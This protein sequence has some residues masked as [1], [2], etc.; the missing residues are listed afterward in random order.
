[1]KSDIPLK[2]TDD[3]TIPGTSPVVIF[4]PNGAGKTRHAT[5]MAE[6]NNADMI[7]ALRNIALSPNLDMLSLGKAS[8]N[9][10]EHLNQ[11]RSQAWSQ[12]NEIN[13]LFSKLMAEDSTA[14]ILFRDAYIMNQPIKPENTKI[15][16]LSK[17]WARLF[18]GM[19]IDFSGYQ[20]KVRSDFSDSA[21]E[22]PAERMSDGERVALYLAGRVL[23]SESNIIIIDEPEVHFH[24]RLASR[25]WNELETLRP[26]CRF[27]YVTHDL[28]F[29][30]SRNNAQYV[31]IMPNI[32]PQLVSLDDGL[33]KDLANSLLA[34]A[35][36]SIY[37]KRIVFCEGIEGRSRDQAIYSAW[38]AGHETAVVPVETGDNAVQCARTYA[39]STLVAGVEAL[40]IIDRD[41]WPDEYLD[42]LPSY[43][44]ALS[45]HELENLLCL[46]DVFAAIATH[47]G[48]SDDE[49]NIL[50]QSFIDEAKSKFNGTLLHK[51]ISERY[52]RRC[53]KIFDSAMNALNVTN[54]LEAD[55]TNHVR[56]LDLSTR[57]TDPAILFD[58]EKKRL[59]EAL[60][61]D[62]DQFLR[63][64]PGKVFVKDA[65]RKLGLDLNTYIE[66]TCNGLTAE[67][68]NKLYQLGQQLE[69]CLSK[70]LPERHIRG[71]STDT[72]DQTTASNPVT[73]A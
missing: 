7:K 14:A 49:A 47:L 19:Q 51:Q 10:R 36:F 73:E 72:P 56:A 20:P 37:A 18:P 2:L 25:F 13:L 53:K 3:T 38:F 27:V 17:V 4:G 58:E 23:D 39:E 62:E 28:S 5:R 15:M 31:I 30:L 63:L 22:Y 24:S 42:S 8:T 64:Y 44:T 21:G 11:T 71:D 43:I 68:G 33:P 6:L 12:S 26:E 40:A 48:R 67:T 1:M 32:P 50:Y 65:A 69:R 9:L 59:E 46:K 66:I 60:S 45:V 54:D 35:S 34:A 41:Y 70:Y 57:D 16:Q 55:K 29:G 52:R 61:S